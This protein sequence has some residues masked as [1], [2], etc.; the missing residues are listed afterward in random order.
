M[1]TIQVTDDQY[2]FLMRTAKNLK[3]QDNLCTEDPLY[4]VYKKEEQIVDGMYYHDYEVKY[5]HSEYEGFFN[6][7]KE[8]EEWVNEYYGEDKTA[9]QKRKIVSKILDDFHY[10]TEKDVFVAAFLTREAAERFMNANRYHWHKP[11]IYVESN[12]RNNEMITLRKI[13]LG[14]NNE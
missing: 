10:V 1:K 9:E 2:E 13:L 14:L 6:D 3:T 5:R 4:V 11:H 8:V 12:W 7:R